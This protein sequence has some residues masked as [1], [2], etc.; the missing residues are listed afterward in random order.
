MFLR[1]IWMTLHLSMWRITFRSFNPILYV[2]YDQRESHTQTLFNETLSRSIIQFL[3]SPT[4]LSVVRSLAF[5]S[6]GESFSTDGYESH[7]KGQSASGQSLDIFGISSI[8]PSS[9]KGK[10]KG[11]SGGNHPSTGV[12][13]PSKQSPSV[14]TV[15]A[16]KNAPKFSPI[17]FPRLG[18]AMLPE[19][20]CVVSANV[21]LLVSVLRVLLQQGISFYKIA[22]IFGIT[23]FLPIFI[24][25]C[26]VCNG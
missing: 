5:A 22:D 19:L 24:E 3:T 16:I 9:V 4:H 13:D 11:K 21:P 23:K 18:L 8:P 1:V 10:G 6:M 17:S 15:T 25:C 20:G 2:I 12:H 7:A 14:S 26:F